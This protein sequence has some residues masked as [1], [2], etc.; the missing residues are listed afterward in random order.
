MIK[1]TVRK[2]LVDLKAVAALLEDNDGAPP[3]RS[4]Y[5]PREDLIQEAARIKSQRDLILQRISRMEQN[6]NRVS[7]NVFDKVNRDYSMQMN[8]ISDLLNEKKSLLN[9]ELKNLYSLREK[10]NVEMN[11]HKEILEEAQF[12]HFLSEFTEE[13][14]K[15]VE[16]YESKEITHLQSELAKLHTFIK[17][18]EELF[19]PQDLGFA[20][21]PPAQAPQKTPEPTSTKSTKVPVSSPPPHLEQVRLGYSRVES[22]ADF[23]EK[24]PLPTSDTVIRSSEEENKDEYDFDSLLEPSESDYFQP[25]SLEPEK[26]ATP[27]S[28]SSPSAQKESSLTQVTSPDLSKEPSLTTK[29]AAAM[30]ESI[31]DILGSTHGNIKVNLSNNANA[32]VGP[33]DNSLTPKPLASPSTDSYKLVFTEGAPENMTEFV[34]NEN[35]SIGRSPSNDVVFPAPKVSRQHAAINKYKDKYILIDLK[36]SNGVFV[37]GKKVDEHTLE[38]GDDISISGFRM[39]F[40]KV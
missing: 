23:S 11:R 28:T 2:K 3:V 25:E 37:N 14:Y 10:Q 6:K 20:A 35:V 9:K 8:A 38:E 29:T 17:I 24:T 32:P 21:P 31:N 18:H 30:E 26:N 12:R 16:E 15:E 5:T 19:D 1:K 7:K 13:Q 33:M 36:S 4:L 34:L 39:I 22:K 40:K 27:E